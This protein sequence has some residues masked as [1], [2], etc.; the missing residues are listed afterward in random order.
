MPQSANFSAQNALKLTYK[1]PEIPKK[2]LGSLSLAIKGRGTK[3][4]GR[5]REGLGKGG[6]ERDGGEKTLTPKF[7]DRSPPLQSFNR[8]VYSC[9]S[10]RGGGGT[11]NYAVHTIITAYFVGSFRSRSILI[12]FYNPCFSINMSNEHG[13]ALLFRLRLK[14]STMHGQSASLSSLYLD[15]GI[16]SFGSPCDDHCHPDFPVFP[17][18]SSLS[19]SVDNVCNV[20]MQY[21]LKASERFK[22]MARGIVL[23]FETQDNV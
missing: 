23:G 13:P 19:L 14:T 12:G 17:L 15:F 6:E 5:G 16:D 20:E 22:K 8:R 1:H 3:G 7:S 9:I 21:M 10:F 4:K 18:C 11:I 2:F